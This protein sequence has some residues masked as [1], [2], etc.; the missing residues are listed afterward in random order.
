MFI[1]LLTT[2][3]WADYAPDVI[4]ESDTELTLV[5]MDGRSVTIPQPV[6]KIVAV[7]FGFIEGTLYA[8]GAEDT[9]VG[10]GGGIRSNVTADNLIPTLREL[11][12]AGSPIDGIN[13]ETIAAIDPD[14]VIVRKN[15]YFKE[16]TDKGVEMIEGLGIPV[17]VLMDPNN[18]H[19]S[20][21]DT[22]YQ[23]IALLGT[24]VGKEEKAKELIDKIDARVSQIVERTEGIEDKD[25]PAVLFTGLGSSSTRDKGGV[26]VVWAKECASTF[27]DLINIQ[28]AYDG[29][30]RNVLSAEQVLQLDPDVIILE[31]S[32]GGY[33]ISQIY[34][35]DYYKNIQEVSAI[36]DKKVYTIGKLTSCGDIQLD[37]PI[38]LLIEAKGTYPEKFSDINVSEWIEEYY[39][40]I[41][42]ISKDMAK[43]LKNTQGLDWVD[44]YGF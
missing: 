12:N 40:D 39:M 32:S 13:L 15:V 7:G 5:D 8:L 36:K 25:K 41:F 22:M 23:E 3:C 44:T 43:E 9:L 4:S 34:D 6:D 2:T 33:N 30:G 24:I 27:A 1:V 20:D 17:V 29:E 21:I 42:G 18:F 14:L 16:K 38:I 11:P 37:L 19:T 10:T 31:T 35:E 26:L 28:S